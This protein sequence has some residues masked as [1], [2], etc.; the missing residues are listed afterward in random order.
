VAS[1]IRGGP[2]ATRI[3]GGAKTVFFRFKFL[4]LPKRGVAI[5]VRNFRNGKPL[6]R[7]PVGKRRAAV[8]DSFVQSASGLL[9]SGRWKAVLYVGGKAVAAASVRLG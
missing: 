4:S 3:P 2:A 6:G 1:A 5:A 8:V 9:P 7:R